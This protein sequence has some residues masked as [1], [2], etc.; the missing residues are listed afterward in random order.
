MQQRLS[1][2]V[3]GTRVW[4]GMADYAVVS[5]DQATTLYLPYVGEP[6]HGDSQHRIHTKD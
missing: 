4:F 1:A 3:D 2:P 5:P 6:P